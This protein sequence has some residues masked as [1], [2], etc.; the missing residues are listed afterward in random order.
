MSSNETAHA[1]HVTPLW[2][3]MGVWA[4]LMV[5]TGITVWVAHFDFGAFNTVVAMAVATIKA[6]LVALFFMGLFWDERVNLFSFLTTLVFVGLFFVFVFADTMTRGAVDPI[7]R[8][9][10]KEMPPAPTAGQLG[11]KPEHHAAP[12]G[13]EAPAG[14]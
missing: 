1:H 8:N 2:I 4:S 7:E 14:H 3:L 10:V 12:A 9:F 11:K 13:H 6:S 5:L